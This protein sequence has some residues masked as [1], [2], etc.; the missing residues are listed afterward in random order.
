MTMISK[1]HI[2]RIERLI[3]DLDQ[4]EAALASHYGPMVKGTHRAVNW[5]TSVALKAALAAL[6]GDPRE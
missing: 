2:T 5:H 1:K 3:K 6:K 4:R